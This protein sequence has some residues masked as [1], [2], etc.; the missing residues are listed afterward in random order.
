MLK[1]MDL[2]SFAENTVKN[3]SK[4]ISKNLIGNKVKNLLIMLK[5]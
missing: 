4:N 2:F 3:I 5:N 1:A